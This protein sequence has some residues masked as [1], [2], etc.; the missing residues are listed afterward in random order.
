MNLA[1]WRAL[2]YSILYDEVKERN[3]SRIY[4]KKELAQE[5]PLP[6]I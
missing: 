2:L 6:L 3:F 5:L 4:F 1:Q